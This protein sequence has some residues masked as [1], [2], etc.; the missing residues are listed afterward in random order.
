MLAELMA[1]EAQKQ[2]QEAGK[3]ADRGTILALEAH[4]RINRILEELGEA[5][6]NPGY[7]FSNVVETA[8]R[9]TGKNSK[10]DWNY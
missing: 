10:G 9:I 6:T 1:L 4:D 3:S 2:A 5:L 7:R 8:K